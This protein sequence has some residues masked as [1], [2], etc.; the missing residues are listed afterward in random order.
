MYNVYQSREV[1]VSGDEELDHVSGSPQPY[2]GLAVCVTNEKGFA[3]FVKNTRTEIERQI[4]ELNGEIQEM[5]REMQELKADMREMNREIREMK[6]EL[7]ADMREMNREMRE[8]Q[9]LK[10]DIREMIREMREMQELKADI[11]EMNREMREMQ[12]LK[13]D[14]RVMNRG[15]REMQELKADIRV[16]KECM[17]RLS[18]SASADWNIN[19]RDKIRDESDGSVQIKL[20][21]T[22]SR[23]TVEL[24]PLSSMEIEIVVLDGDF[25]YEGNENWTEQEFNAKIVQQRKSKGPLV[26]GKQN[27]TLR[28]GVGIIDDLSFSDNSSWKD[29]GKFRL[30]ARVLQSRSRDQARIKEA[31]SQAFVVN[32]FRMRVYHEKR[33]KKL[34]LPSLDND[35]SPLKKI[36]KNAKCHTD[37]N[38]HTVKDF[39]QIHGTDLN[40]QIEVMATMM[41]DWYYVN[42]SILNF[43]LQILKD[44][45]D[46]D[47]EVIVQ[48]AS[49]VVDD[50]KLNASTN[51]ILSQ[52]T[53]S[54]L[55]YEFAAPY[56]GFS[57]MQN[58]NN[59]ASSSQDHKG[60]FSTAEEIVPNLASQPLDTSTGYPVNAQGVQSN[61]NGVSGQNSS[62]SNYNP[63]MT[64]SS[65]IN[66]GPHSHFPAE[67]H[68]FNAFD[69]TRANAFSNPLISQEEAEAYDNRTTGLAGMQNDCNPA[70]SSQYELWP[71]I[72]QNDV[73]GDPKWNPSQLKEI[74]NFPPSPNYITTKTSPI[75]TDSKIGAEIDGPL[76]IVLIDTISKA[77]V[78][79]GPLS[80]ISIR[81]LVLDGDFGFGFEDQENWT[82]QDL[83]AK[84]VHEREGKRPLV[85]GELDITLRDGIG[86]IS[87]ISFIDNSSRIKC[88]KFRLGA[89][90]VQSIGGQVRIKEAISEAFVVQK[91]TDRLHVHLANPPSLDDEVWHLEKIRKD[92]KSHQQ[93]AP[94]QIDTVKDFMRKYVTDPTKPREVRTTMLFIFLLFNSVYKLVAATFDGQNYQSVDDPTFSH[95]NACGKFKLRVTK[96]QYGSSENQGSNKSSFCSEELLWKNWNACGKFRLGARVLQRSSMGQVRI[97]EAISQAFAVRNY[98]GK[99][100]F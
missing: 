59:H 67:Q 10:A 42:E 57:G 84:V 72:V 82:E 50:E 68:V 5:N 52:T 56:Q 97:K 58:A 9:E 12:E 4:R 95:K 93:L 44:C 27:I 34:D 78:T 17:Q 40:K 74:S 80:L 47:R 70:S 76:K 29:C 89:R 45:S 39:K 11:R 63:L 25:G 36:K 21:D 30:G 73:Y 96:E 1:L 37:N 85:T 28:K 22:I 77:T 94:H 75:F 7:K 31:I 65:Q 16:M 69:D 26:K 98:R 49:C 13:A 100:K 20:I 35:A 55:H 86:I 71:E 43:G 62:Q 99:S 91:K 2:T 8:M 64:E 87:D 23:E 81:I 90:V 53:D 24:D 41:L 51:P 92:G 61:S 18:R 46:S 83:N 48:D 14:I 60:G 3:E 33:S 15:M 6:R 38:I 19:A 88:Q 66:N 79:S 32:D 54:Q